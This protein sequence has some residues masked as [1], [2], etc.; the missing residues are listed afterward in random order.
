VPS[1]PVELE[2]QFLDS[3]GVTD[4]LSP[5]TTFATSSE[6]K[7]W[8][9]MV[10]LICLL[11]ALLLFGRNLDF[12]AYAHPDEPSKIA[13]I[14]EGIYNFNHPLLMLNSVRFFAEA[15]GKSQD[16]EFVKLAGR[17]SS[18][19]YSSLAVGLLVLVAGRLYGQLVA[20]AAGLFLISN[21]M[22][23]QLARFFK[24]D[25]ALLFGISLTLVAMLV[26]LSSRSTPS[27]VFLGLATACAVSGKY[28][29]ALIIPFSIYII[30]VCSEN[31]F[32]D[33]ATMLFCFATTFLLIN[34]PAFWNPDAA[35]R[36]LQKEVDL[37]TGA[38]PHKFLVAV[39]HRVY[40]R[41]YLESANPIL[42]GLL[43]AYGY[44]LIKRG[45][46]LVPVEWVLVA[47]PALYVTLLSF[48]TRPFDRYLLPAAS[49][50]ACLSAVGLLTVLKLKH[51]TVIA[52]LLVGATLAWQ[53]PRLYQADRGFQQD[54]PRILLIPAADL[55]FAQHPQVG[56][57][58]IGR[59][60]VT[61]H[62]QASGIF[63]T[64]LS[65]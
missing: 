65:R 2:T 4:S 37:L 43:L 31:K 8:P 58:P 47:W 54:K 40:A 13:Q 19:I 3:T 10:A 45:F 50:L 26:F 15:L 35:S 48:Q 32:R 16:F 21:P 34:V 1:L 22:L 23:F 29:G 5:R 59:A 61:R 53:I 25:P 9:W 18:V 20:A 6:L 38:R 55:L 44:G 33:L 57:F 27:A 51:G 17:W 7:P 52:L 39:P 46:R 41:V 64:R 36:S 30:L 14:V 24:E 49:I 63:L 12:S 56:L 62:T 60:E 11:I 28:A 42:A